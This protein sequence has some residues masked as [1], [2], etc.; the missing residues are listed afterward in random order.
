MPLSCCRVWPLSCWWE[1]SS[2]AL[3]APGTPGH[4]RIPGSRAY[5]RALIALTQPINRNKTLPFLMRSLSS[6][7]GNPRRPGR[8]LGRT[9]WSMHGT[10]PSLPGPGRP[11]LFVDC[12][13][14]P[15]PS[16][17]LPELIWQS[18]CWRRRKRSSQ[19]V[20]HLP[21]RCTAQKTQGSENAQDLG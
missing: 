3:G 16:P 1:L 5:M 8:G 2:W 9:G 20:F 11:V 7:C 17:Y 6:T 10:A 12:E 21:L 4:M 13:Q 19:F 18:F 14:V 15:P